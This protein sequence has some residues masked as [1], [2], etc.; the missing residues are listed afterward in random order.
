[1]IKDKTKAQYFQGNSAID[2]SHSKW[3]IILEKII[4]IVILERSRDNKGLCIYDMEKND[5]LAH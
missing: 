2:R 4:D 5:I 1:M 3:K